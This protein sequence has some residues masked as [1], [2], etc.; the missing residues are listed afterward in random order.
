MITLKITYKNGNE[1]IQKVNYVH[2]EDN[3]I[4][5]TRAT[6]PSP[7][8]REPVSIPLDNIKTLDIIQEK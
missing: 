6:N 1:L 5:Y 7:V 8:F 3:Q 2:I 4:F